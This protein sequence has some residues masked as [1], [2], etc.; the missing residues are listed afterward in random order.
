[1][2]DLAVPAKKFARVSRFFVFRKQIGH[3]TRVHFPLLYLVGCGSMV[4]Q[5]K[6]IAAYFAYRKKDKYEKGTFTPSGGDLSA[7]YVRM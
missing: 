5:Y 2:N 1:M 4:M 7:D 6:I 3:E